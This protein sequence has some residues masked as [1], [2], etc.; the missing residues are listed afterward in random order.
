MPTLQRALEIAVVHHAG[1]TDKSG[2]PYALHS[3]RVSMKLDTEAAKITAL[4][5]DI[6]ED[7]SIT[8]AD[9]REEGFT[10]EIIEA[11]DLLTH[12]RLD[13]YEDYVAKIAAN[14]IARAVKLADLEDNMDIRR[15]R[16]PL[17][18]KD[19]ARLEK[20]RSAWVALRA[21]GLTTATA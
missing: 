10:P 3:I 7:T 15:L 1:Q 14:P 19:H 11:V 5:H 18:E 21:H 9:L 16:A 20:Y 8:L 17:T 6:V 12:R 13:P 2:E 4:L